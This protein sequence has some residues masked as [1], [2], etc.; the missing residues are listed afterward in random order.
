[1]RRSNTV[2]AEPDS[3]ITLPIGWS[4]P[5]STKEKR[6]YYFNENTGESRWDPPT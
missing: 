5:W 3:T 1:P 4:K 6:F 2:I